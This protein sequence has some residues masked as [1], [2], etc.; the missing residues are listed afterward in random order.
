MNKE[1]RKQFDDHV[2]CI[3]VSRGRL[4]WKPGKLQ[5]VGLLFLIRG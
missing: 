5:R 4:V 3:I 2:H 1:T